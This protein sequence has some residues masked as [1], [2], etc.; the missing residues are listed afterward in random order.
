M[1][2]SPMILLWN[3]NFH[4]FEI[5]IITQMIRNPEPIIKVNKLIVPSTFKR[6]LKIKPWKTKANLL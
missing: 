1:S 2:Y 4:I 5:A 3:Y 6:Q